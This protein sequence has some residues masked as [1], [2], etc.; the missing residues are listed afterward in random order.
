MA[1][2]KREASVARVAI[3]A[4]Y[5]ELVNQVDE[6]PDEIQPDIY[7]DFKA[8][9]RAIKEQREEKE[10]LLKLVEVEREKTEK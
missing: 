7:Q 8:L 6:V 2:Y 9:K 5:K 1:D 10:L 3:D 4:L